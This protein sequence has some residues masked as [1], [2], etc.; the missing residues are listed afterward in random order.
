MKSIIT[1]NSSSQSAFQQKRGF[2]YRCYL[3]P[4][5][6]KTKEFIVEEYESGNTENTIKFLKCLFSKRKGKRLAIFGIDQPIMNQNNS[7]NI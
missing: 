6:Y 5:D 3:N 2:L 4:L 1:S 7:R